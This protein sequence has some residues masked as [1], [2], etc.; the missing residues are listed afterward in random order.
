MDKFKIALIP[1]DGVGNEVVGAAKR[2]LEAISQKREG[3]QFEFTEYPAGKS[4][5]DKIKDALPVITLEGIRQSNATL[6]GAIASG[7]VPHQSPMGRLRNE[8]DLYVDIRPIHSYPRVWCLKEGLDFVFIRE[9]VHGFL[10]DRNLYKGYGEFMPDE[11]TVLSLRVLTR[12]GCER[13]AR[14]AFDYATKHSRK[15]VTVIHKANVFRMGCGF[16]LDICKEVARNYP[17]I[18]VQDEYV[19]HVANKLISNPEDYDVMLT[20]NM[21][22]DIIAD[23][24]AALVSSLV[25]TANIGQGGAIFRPN[26]GALLEIAGKNVVN[27]IPTILCAVM[28]LEYL[29]ALQPAISV[30]KAIETVLAKGDVITSDL[31]G[32]STTSEVT[33]TIVETLLKLG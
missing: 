22:G 23:E 19:D 13:I 16:F 7:L 32:K 25:P 10:P 20:T 8:L 2:V 17:N 30:K 3:L 15:K 6:L 29:G 26:H 21:F 4:A 9:A 31:G 24:A 14:Y 33:Q 27:P 5:Y 1:G 18:E 11:D 12:K 28:M